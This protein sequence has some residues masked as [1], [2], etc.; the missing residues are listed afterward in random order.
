M[1]ITLLTIIIAAVCVVNSKAMN[2]VSSDSEDI[3]T[4]FYMDF[5]PDPINAAA[6]AL[7][8]I[9]DIDSL[10]QETDESE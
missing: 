7:I 1:K 5:N 10:Q 9:E 3:P 6:Q 2:S 8:A 4:I